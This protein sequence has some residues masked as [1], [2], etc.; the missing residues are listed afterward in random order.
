MDEN[1][2]FTDDGSD[3][4]LLFQMMLDLG[5]SLSAKIIHEGYLFCVDGKYLIACFERVFNIC[6]R[7]TIRRIL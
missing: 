3:K 4:D 6:F 1:G 5:V 2:Y 7:K